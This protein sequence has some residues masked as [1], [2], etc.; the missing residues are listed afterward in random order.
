MTD[1]DLLN[2]VFARQSPSGAWRMP[3]DWFSPKSVATQVKWSDAIDA[4]QM[5]KGEE[6][7]KFVSR[8]DNIVGILASLV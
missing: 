1:T 4:V 2:R 8:V 5:D 6:P 3:R 7:M